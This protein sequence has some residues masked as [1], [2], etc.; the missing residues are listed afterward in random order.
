MTA[1]WGGM[2]E[3]VGIGLWVAF[4]I[5]NMG[6]DAAQN[7][8]ILQTAECFHA[9]LQIVHMVLLECIDLALGGVLCLLVV[10]VSKDSCK[11]VL[12]AVFDKDPVD[13]F[14]TWLLG[15]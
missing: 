9:L 4:E 14:T 1:E 8:S 12:G 13:D 10:V 11:Q 6:E 3:E 15:I 5:F 2:F 7:V